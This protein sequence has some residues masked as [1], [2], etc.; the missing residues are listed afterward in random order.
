MATYAQE[1]VVLLIG[2]IILLNLIILQLEYLGNTETKEIIDNFY[3]HQ[4]ENGTK[5]M[6]VIFL[7]ALFTSWVAPCTVWTSNLL[8]KSK[9]LIVSSSITFFVHLINLINLYLIADSNMLNYIENPPILH[10]FHSHKKLSNISYN[11]YYSKNEKKSMINVCTQNDKCLPVMRICSENEMQTDLMLTYVIPLGI[12]LIVTSFL[13]SLRLQVLSNYTKMYAFLRTVCLACPK[14]FYWFLTDFILHYNK[15]KESLRKQV[16]NNI[17]KEVT[18]N[19]AYKASIQCVLT[20]HSEYFERSEETKHLKIKLEEITK[21][22]DKKDISQ[23]V[24]KLPPMHA[25]VDNNKLGLWS[26][27]Y[28]LG[29]EAG[30]LNGQTKSSINLIMEKYKNDNTLLKNCSIV[31]QYLI[32]KATEKYGE[33]AFH[34]A[35]KLED[36]QLMKILIANGYNINKSDNNNK[37]PMLLALEMRN[38]DFLRFL[39]Q[40]G[41]NVLKE[42]VTFAGSF[43]SYNYLILLLKYV[44]N[45]SEIDTLLFKAALDGNLK[46]LKLLLE[47]KANVNAKHKDGQTLIHI[48]TTKGDLECLKYLIDNKADVNVK[49]DGQTPLHISANRG[50]LEC[51]KYLIDNK[52]D[53]NATDYYGRSSLHMS[54]WRGQLDCCKYLIDNKADVNVKFDGQTPLHISVKEGHFECCKYLIDNKSDVNSKDKKGQT[55]LHI[56]AWEG[57]FDCMK[58]LIDKKANV[59][60][61]NGEGQT[62]LFH[63]IQNGHLDCCK[64]LIDNKA[65]LNAKDTQGQT[66]LHTCAFHGDQN[67]FKFLIENKLDLNVKDQNGQTPLHI[68]ASE[69]RLKCLQYLIKNKVDVNGKDK[70][71]HTPLQLS[72]MKGHLSCCKY[73]IDNKA[74]LNVKDKTGQTLLHISARMCQFECCK[75]FIDQKADVNASDLEHNTPLHMVGSFSGGIKLKQIECAE[76]L[77]KE[78]ADLNASNVHGKKP[79]TLKQLMEENP[80]FFQ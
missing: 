47:N 64:Y 55:P 31:T 13:S 21:E 34:Q 57:H 69:G 78:G 41:A 59:N 4:K 62:P 17:K 77:I 53:A 10:C 60:A 76:L 1:Y 48:S 24:W 38:M 27:M 67:C 71:G 32:K 39:L 72:A 52:A 6:Y 56:S 19:M 9:F 35:I 45:I 66:L 44:T 70:D 68:T 22:N 73:L 40:H 20:R 7:N 63:S 18:K 11:Y 16:L 75:C 42:H 14:T 37:T 8:Q 65:E 5:E 23:L 25:A 49:F 33:Y 80:S 28:I 46:L 79:I 3:N 54:A 51:M 2:T 26:F 15:L 58:Y 29:G 30:A 50:D 61:R 43:E 12:L 74:D 36:M